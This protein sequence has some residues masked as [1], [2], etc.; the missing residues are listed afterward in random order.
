MAILTAEE[1]AQSKMQHSKAKE[2][3]RRTLPLGK[4]N[5]VIVQHAKAQAE[6]REAMTPEEKQEVKL[7]H[8]QAKT[9]RIT[10]LTAKE[11]ARR[12]LQ[13]SRGQEKFIWKSLFANFQFAIHILLTRVLEEKKKEREILN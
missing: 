3:F 8:V 2:K 13:H 7:Q 10:I 9:Q 1:K 11:K 5:S 4:K 12:K 6:F